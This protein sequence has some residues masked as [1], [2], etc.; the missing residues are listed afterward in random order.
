MRISCRSFPQRCGSGLRQWQIAQAYQSSGELQKAL[1]FGDKALAASPHNLDILVSQANIAAQAK[2]DASL[3]DYAARGGEACQ[4]V[5]K[6]AKPEGMSDV[7]FARKVTE[8]KE[9]IQSNCDFLESSGLNAISGESDAKL[10][11][12]HIEKF[13]AAFPNSKYQETV[14]NLALESLSQLNDNARLV[15]Y[16]E[17]ILTS[18]PNSLPAL[19]LL[20]NF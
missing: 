1:E 19:L 9:A 3:M 12:T 11:M 6:Q 17:K 5:A 10:R 16:G 4:S 2:N 14:S 8:E 13:T 15:A 20:A 18:D 7:D